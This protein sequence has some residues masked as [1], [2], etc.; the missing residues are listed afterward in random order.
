MVSYT[1]EIINHHAIDNGDVEV[2]LSEFSVEYNSESVPYPETN[3]IKLI[4]DNEMDHLLKLFHSE[5][6]D[7]LLDVEL[8]MIQD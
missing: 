2:N 6:D 1:R 3:L 8:C 4:D 5:H 7:Y